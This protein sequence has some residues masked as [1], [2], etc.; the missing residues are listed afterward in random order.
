M[1]IEAGRQGNAVAFV[2]KHIP[3]IVTGLVI[4]GGAS[5]VMYGTGDS[6]VSAMSA[7]REI[8]RSLQ[9]AGISPDKY[10]EAE[11]KI[12]DILEQ[13]EQAL[14][15]VRPGEEMLAI[16]DK[17]EN[18]ETIDVYSQGHHSIKPGLPI[19]SRRGEG[20]VV[21]GLAVATSGVVV[22]FSLQTNKQEK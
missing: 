2:K 10:R 6:I 14:R 12:P 4:L 18:R 20:F 15:E 16:L 22:L 17:P 5:S 9:E 11:S 13:I 7:N 8:N 19:N 3:E 1:S 21:G